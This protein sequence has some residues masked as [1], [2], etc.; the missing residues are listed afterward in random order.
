MSLVSDL[1]AACD[2]E[3]GLTGALFPCKSMNLLNLVNFRD[4][5]ELG[6]EFAVTSHTAQSAIWGWTNHWVGRTRN[7]QRICLGNHVG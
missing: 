1:E 4:G 7:Q 6:S 3:T 5:E 2:P